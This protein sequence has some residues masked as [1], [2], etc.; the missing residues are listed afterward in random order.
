MLLNASEGHLLSRQASWAQSQL[1]CRRWR[2]PDCVPLSLQGSEET[3]QKRKRGPYQELDGGLKRQSTDGGVS[4]VKDMQRLGAHAAAE[5]G[6]GDMLHDEEGDAKS[7]PA[8]TRGKGACSDDVVLV[9][10]PAEP[11]ASDDVQIVEVDASASGPQPRQQGYQAGASD[12]ADLAARI[13]AEMDGLHQHV[14]QMQPLFPSAACPA[15]GMPSKAQACIQSYV[16]PLW[17]ELR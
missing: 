15:G 9:D 17:I 3:A 4:R 12:R 6:G 8:G 14:R 10:Q 7:P 5:T 11:C 16:Q 2:L 1:A 13:M